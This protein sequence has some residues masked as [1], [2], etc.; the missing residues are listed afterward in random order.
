[1]LDDIPPEWTI[2]PIGDLLEPLEDG[3]TIHQGWSPQCERHPADSTE[4][5]GV[6][7]TTAIQDGSFHPEHN[8]KLPSHLEPR[9]QL[10]V[11]EGDILITCAGPRARCGVPCK[12]RSTRPRLMMSGKMYRF[13]GAEDRISSAYLEGTGRV[14]SSHWAGR[15]QYQGRYWG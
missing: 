11:R 14:P 15:L 5:W 2:A 8:K 4:Q 3:R 7:K 13:R 9:P 10:E 1:M 12:V 6:L